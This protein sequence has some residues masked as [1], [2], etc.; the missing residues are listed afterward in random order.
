[1]PT[2]TIQL[3]DAALTVEVASTVGQRSQGLMHRDHLGAARGMLFVYKDEAIRHF[4]M[5]DTRIPL[6]IAFADRTGKI[7]KIS[8]MRP[9]DSS[10]TTSLYPVKYA[11]EVNQ[12]WFEEQK[13]TAGVTLQGLEGL[14]LSEDKR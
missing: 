7:M 2:A 3:G 1:M 11:L 12:G 8:D 13:I 6:S 10:R 14:P 4:W 5:K 9:Y